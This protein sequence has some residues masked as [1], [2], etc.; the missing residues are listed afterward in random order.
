M[1]AG[2]DL[3]V[4]AIGERMDVGFGRRVVL[5]VQFRAGEVAGHHVLGGD[6]GVG[7]SVGGDDE[8]LAPGNPDAEVP[9]G[10]HYQTEIICPPRGGHDLAAYL[11]L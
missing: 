7:N 3:V 11:Y 8:T 10:V 5:P 6:T 9:L 1:H 2:A 4:A